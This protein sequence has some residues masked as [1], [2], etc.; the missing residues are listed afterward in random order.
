MKTIVRSLA[1]VSFAFAAAA[2]GGASN[3]ES[4]TSSEA[5][6]TL[7][8]P[9]P[10]A[11][12]YQIDW[13]DPTTDEISLL[14]LATNGT[15]WGERCADAACVK[16]DG[17]SGTF[18]YTKTK[19]RLYDGQHALIASYYYALDQGT[20]WLEQAGSRD[21]YPLDPMSEALCDSSGGSWSDDDLAA[22]GFNCT[23]PDGQDW[24]PGGCTGC[25]YGQ[26]AQSC[27]APL[28]ACGTQCVDLTTDRSNCGACNATCTK[29]QSC[30]NGAC[31]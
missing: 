26:C 19:L 1:L 9:F 13:S 8:A 31:K 22:H 23:C 7:S 11:G 5:E 29:A 12:Y 15:F 2:C 21:A 10:G 17:L 27:T 18:K 6:V 14:S 24:G 4:A 3:D 25:P 28:T 20:L 30:V 16:V